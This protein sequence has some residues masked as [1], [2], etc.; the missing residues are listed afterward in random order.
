M[1]SWFLP[2]ILLIFALL[3]V[4]TLSSIAPTL[5]PR[6]LLFFLLGG[7][8]FWIAAKMNFSDSLRLSPL[9][10]VV[11]ILLLVLVL[12]VGLTTRGTRSWIDFGEFRMQPSQL[13]IPLVGL[14]LARL[15]ESRQLKK[16]SQ[17]IKALVVIAIPGLLILIEPDLGTTVVYL[18]TV[19]TIVFFKDLNWRHVLFLGLLALVGLIIAWFFVLHPYQQLRISS[20]LDPNKNTQMTAANYNAQQS[21]IAVG[22]GQWLGR[23]LGQGVQSHLRFLP[24]RQTDF[25][26]A[27]LAEEFGFLGS[28]L[29]IG[30]YTALISFFI[31]IGLNSRKESEALF[32]YMATSMI[33]VQAGVNIGM[34][35]GL[36]PI[37][38][39]TLPLLSYGGSS[40][41]TIMG[42]MGIL[43]SIARNQQKQVLLNIS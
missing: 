16:F 25:I 19:G 14:F 5:A 3:S 15:V 40:V 8:V 39:I 41:I 35:M 36:L 28:A 23:G 13:A 12:V 21:L 31:F 24:E 18:A 9:G 17:L 30:L 1:R 7:V 33:L 22:S 32:C 34:N 27:S 4:L 42:M 6:Q 29:L 37:T 11:T 2:A 43:Q 10:Y 26:F 38:G 20:F